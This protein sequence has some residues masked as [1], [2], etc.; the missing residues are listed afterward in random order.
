M[1]SLEGKRIFIVEDNLDNRRVMR[2]ALE[3]CG[4]TVSFDVWGAQ[5]V[6]HLMA[7]WP[8]DVVLLDLMFPR[9]VDGFDVYDK[10]RAESR[11]ARLPVVAVSASDISYALPKCKAKGFAGFIP[12]PIDIDIFP[13][14]ILRVSQGEEVWY[15][16]Q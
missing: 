16:E 2:L 11:F 13:D 4:A 1:N 14:Q 15:A 9:N 12:K 8:I 7:N 3:A 6:I 10:I 5:T